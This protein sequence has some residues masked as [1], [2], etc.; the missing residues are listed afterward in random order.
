MPFLNEDRLD[1][2]ITT[3]S[4][5]HIALAVVAAAALGFVFGALLF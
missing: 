2:R 3:W 1:S 5:G 4:G